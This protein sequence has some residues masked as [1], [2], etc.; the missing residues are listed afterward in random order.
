MGKHKRKKE[1]AQTPE[2]TVATVLAPEDIA[3]GDYVGVLSATYDLIGLPSCVGEP[4]PL[5]VHRVAFIPNDT[6][7]PLLVEGVCV[8][9]VLVKD[10]KGKRRVIDVRRFRLAR[11]APEFG[12]Q[13]FSLMRPAARGEG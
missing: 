6:D 2:M 8:P 10:T 5:A 3:V 13:V 1:N 4:R 12:A 9:F 7:P 11:V